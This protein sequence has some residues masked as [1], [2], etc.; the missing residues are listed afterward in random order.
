MAHS[1]AVT[2]ALP[3]LCCSRSGIISRVRSLAKPRAAGCSSDH[4]TGGLLLIL[5]VTLSCENPSAHARAP[6]LRQVLVL[7]GQPGEGPSPLT[8]TSSRGNISSAQAG[9]SP[10]FSPQK[11]A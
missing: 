11:P 9:F 10:F 5:P 2:P 4:L 1:D 6:I 3:W 8:S 7:S